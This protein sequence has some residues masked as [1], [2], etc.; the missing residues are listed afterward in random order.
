MAG[1]FFSDILLYMAFKY[2]NYSKAICLMLTQNIMIPFVARCFLRDPVQRSDIVASAV[3]FVGMVLIVQP[4]GGKMGSDGG[5][6]AGTA[7]IV[8]PVMN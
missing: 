8:K 2:T 7:E 1:G 5:L 3:S 6:T 4:F